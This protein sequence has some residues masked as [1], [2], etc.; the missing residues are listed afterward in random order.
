[1]KFY[2]LTKLCFSDAPQTNAIADDS[3]DFCDSLIVTFQY[4][5]NLILCKYYY[6]LAV[7]FTRLIARPN[8]EYDVYVFVENHYKHVCIKIVTYEY[9]TNLPFEYLNQCFVV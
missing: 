8:Y 5:T 1:M 9:V 2:I 4:G 3:S 7:I 6:F